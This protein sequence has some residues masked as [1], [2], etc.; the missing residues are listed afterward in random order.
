[1]IRARGHI[2]GP[3]IGDIAAIMKDAEEDSERS[4]G[5]VWDFTAAHRVVAVHRSG[6]GLQA[7]TLADLRGKTPSDEDDLYLNTVGT[8][9]FSTAEHWWGRLAAALMR[10]GHYFLGHELSCRLMLFADD[11]LALPPLAHFRPP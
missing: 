5:L 1:M 8:F 6:W 2:P 9:G 3:L 10:A 4:L 11:G 7:C